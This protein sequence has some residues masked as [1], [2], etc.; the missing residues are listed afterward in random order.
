MIR[1]FP[2]GRRGVALHNEKRRKKAIR[3]G[4]LY[5]SHTRNGQ[6]DTRSFFE[7]DLSSVD[8]EKLAT[9]KLRINQVQSYRG[10]AS[11]LPKVNRFAL[12]GLTNSAKANWDLEPGWDESPNPGDG[13]LVGTFEL[14]RSR[15]RGTIEIESPKLLSFLRERGANPV[16]LIL[17]R[18]TGRIDGLG[19]AMPHM[20]ASDKHPEAVGPQ[21]ELTVK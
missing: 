12:Y 20:F 19:P 21:L 17:T 5:A 16:T 10:S 4:Y 7:F 14:P 8:L 13:E 2:Q 18:E 6:W 1:V 11:L 15:M 3:P 9:A